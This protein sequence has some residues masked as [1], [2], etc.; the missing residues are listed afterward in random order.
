MGKGSTLVKKLNPEKKYYNSRLDSEYH[1]EDKNFVIVPLYG[2]NDD[3]FFYVCKTQG[4]IEVM[5]EGY[6]IDR[7]R[8]LKYAKQ[9]IKDIDNLKFVVTAE[10]GDKLSEGLARKILQELLGDQYKEDF[11]LA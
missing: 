9:E 10:N 2:W 3:R 1:G 8:A 11:L 4:M 7:S 6:V 5:G